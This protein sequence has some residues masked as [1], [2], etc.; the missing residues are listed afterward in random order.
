M[1]VVWCA[2]LRV[3][4]GALGVASVMILARLDLV[5]WIIAGITGIWILSRVSRL[6]NESRGRVA[7]EDEG[8]IRAKRILGAFSARAG[9][10]AP[11]VKWRKSRGLAGYDPIEGV[12]EV[13]SRWMDL[14]EQDEAVAAGVLAHE[15]GH[16]LINERVAAKIDLGAREWLVYLGMVG[17]IETSGPARWWLGFGL[18]ASWALGRVVSLAGSRRVERAC[19]QFASELGYAKALYGWMIQQRPNRVPWW[20]K[21]HP[22]PKKRAKYL[23]DGPKYR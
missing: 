16:S 17:F 21:A 5:G 14:L 1:W 22:Q 7:F 13:S 12:I 11:R 4:P 3:A 6:S 20:A 2:R 8:L 18:G 15:L 9:A 23:Q 10:R 19:D